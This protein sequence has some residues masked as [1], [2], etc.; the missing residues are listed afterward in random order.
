M[1]MVAALNA[2]SATFKITVYSD[3][4]KEGVEVDCVVDRIIRLFSNLRLDTGQKFR[5]V[6]KIQ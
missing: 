6:C 1:R 2:T 5:Q 3:V 4:L